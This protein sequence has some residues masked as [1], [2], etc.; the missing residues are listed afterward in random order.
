MDDLDE[1][2][3]DLPRDISPGRDL[4][5]QIAA[6]LMVDPKPLRAGRSR[7]IARTAVAAS[8]IALVGVSVWFARAPLSPNGS[9]TSASSVH[10]AALA[11][12]GPEYLN[13]RER[14]LSVFPRDLAALPAESQ[15]KVA[16]SLEDIH[17]ALRVIDA[18]LA[19]NPGSALLQELLINTC[20]DEMRVLIAVQQAGAAGGTV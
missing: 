14:R 12:L 18:A 17:A 11:T 7:F 13:D 20:Q 5:P 19:Q 8:I 4:W 10:A 6:Q 3:R 2:L 9:G 1:S 16:A 15:A